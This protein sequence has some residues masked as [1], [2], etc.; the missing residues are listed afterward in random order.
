VDG[1]EQ[2]TRKHVFDFDPQLPESELV[3]GAHRITCALVTAGSGAV[4]DPEPTVGWTVTLGEPVSR[5]AKV[6]ATNRGPS[7]SQLS[8]ESQPRVRAGQT[9]MFVVNATDPD[10]D[11]LT[12][13]WLVDGVPQVADGPAF[14]LRPSARMLEGGPRVEVRVDD[15]RL[16]TDDPVPAGGDRLGL[17]TLSLAPIDYRALTLATGAV[18]LDNGQ[19][20]TVA[21]GTWKVSGG[22]GAYGSSSVYSKVRGDTYTYNLK[23]PL[24]GKYDVLVWWTAWA[25]RST[26]VP[27][28]IS[29]AGG[30][31]SVTVNQRIDG[32][33]WNRVGTHDFT[34]GATIK[35]TAVGGGSSVCADAVCLNPL[36]VAAPAPAG[37]IILDDGTSG[38]SYVGK[39][40]ASNAPDPY[41]GRS[42]YAKSSG[43]YTFRRPLSAS[44]TY[45]VYAWWTAWSSRETKVPYEI[46]HSGGTSTVYVNQQANGGKW[47][48]LGRWTF[49]SEARATVTYVGSGSVCADAVRFVPAGSTPPPEEPP[50]PEPTNV[51]LSW[52]APTTNADGTPLSDLAG[53]RLY[54]GTSS[55]SYSRQVDVGKVTTY[56]LSSLTTGK[57]YFGVTAYDFSGNES[58][59]SGEVSTTVP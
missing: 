48:F 24:S 18:I 53:Y 46:A 42:L 19:S 21:S 5:R 28:A 15:G 14:T 23:V 25:S 11:V 33:Q 54:W 32:S 9:R 34:S 50:P 17:W 22:T 41:G 39:W 7:A 52:D 35:L 8:P 29:H 45:D 51:T 59:Y 27:I 30:T 57:Y 40:S 43:S 36:D 31:A 58:D 2:P 55:R 10:G 56:T 38:T 37:E 26:A 12:Y 47:N 20:G 49:G 16:S 1:V 6:G 3:D 44:G 13:R 4:G